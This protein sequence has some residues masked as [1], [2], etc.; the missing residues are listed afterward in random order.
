MSRIDSDM[1]GC[2]QLELIF[3]LGYSTWARNWS[4]WF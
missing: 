4:F 1:F 3:H 2:S